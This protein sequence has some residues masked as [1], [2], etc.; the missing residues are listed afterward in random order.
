VFESERK[1]NSYAESG[2]IALVRVRS[3]PAVEFVF[4]CDEEIQPPSDP[5]IEKGRAQRLARF[6]GSHALPFGGHAH[7]RMRAKCR[8]I[9]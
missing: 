3:V 7:R 1:K 6:C 4:T 5:T 9:T 2:P 8:V